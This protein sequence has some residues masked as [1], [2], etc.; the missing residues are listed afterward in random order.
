MK[1]LFVCMGN[2]CRSPT[3]EGIFRKMVE[4]GPL[5]GK[6]DIDS[7]GTHG[8]HEGAPPDS[9][10][11]AHASKRG[12]DLTMLR[13]REVS[14]SDF[15]RFDYVIAMDDTN[16]RHLRAMCPTRLQNKIELLLEYG[17]EE[18]EYEVPDPYH[19]KPQDFEVALDL[20]EAGCEGL[21]EYLV[22]QQRLRGGI[23][24]AARD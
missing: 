7:A 14:P 22:D 8:Y 12:V 1:V 18:D 13:A 5:K 10:A 6:V 20:I 2:I 21:H 19:G 4:A 11:I 23:S 9:R 15:E 16:R 24:T 3:A 17:G